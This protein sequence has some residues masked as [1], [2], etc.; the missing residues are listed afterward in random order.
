MPSI[1]LITN[2]GSGSADEID[3]AA[4]LA[5]SGAEVEE[6]PIERAS[7][8][9]EHGAERIIVAGG[10]GSIAPAAAVAARLGVELAVIPSG[11]A[12]DF[13]DRMGLPSEIDEALML[14]A[15]GTHTRRV[16]LARLGE[17][18][19]INVASLGLAPAA[20]AAAA[21]LKD[22][23]GALAYAVGA[24]R[25]AG[26][27]QPLSCAVACDGEGLF[28]GQA[29]QVMIGCTGA[30][31]G[32]SR[33]EADADDG[34][35]D[36]VVIEGGARAMLAKRAIGLRRGDVEAQEG[37]HSSRGCEITVSLQ[38][39]ADLNVDGELVDSRQVGGEQLRFRVEPSAVQLV[40]G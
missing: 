26:T 32:G 28:E 4:R 22:A 35:L 24:L 3:I 8:A 14:A 34:Q 21:A 29:W 16:D 23:L 9:A 33:I 36:V 25:A 27:E 7:D 40:I 37:V 10:D 6:F 38:G 18:P 15:A 5:D 2:P 19:F 12:N 39:P 13:A 1:A 17:R 30:F 11:T 31:G 20:A